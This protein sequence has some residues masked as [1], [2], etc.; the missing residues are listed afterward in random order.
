M[1]RQVKVIRDP[2]HGDMEFPS[3]LVT[4]MDTREF[5]RLRGVRQLGTASFVYPGAVHTRFDHSLGTCW[6]A[7]RLLAL[8]GLD[9]TGPERLAVLAYALLHDVTHVPFGHTLEDER[10][11][12]ERHDTPERVR[13]ALPRGELGA[14]L[15][16]LDLLEPVLEIALDPARWEHQITAG[17]VAADLLDYLARDAF[18]CGLSQRY[19]PRIFGL[20]GLEKGKEQW[21]L[22][23]DAQ[24]DGVLRQDALSEII[25]LL[26]IRYFLSERVY[27]HHTKTV[28]GAMISRAVEEAVGRDLT[29]ERLSRLTDEGLCTM[30]ESSYGDLP[31]VA[32]LMDCLRS[33]RLYKRVFLLTAEL[34]E[35]RRRHFVDLYHYDPHRRAQAEIDIARLCKLRPDQLIVYCPASKM[36]LKEGRLPVKVDGGPLRNLD[37]L[38]V[39]EI[40]ILKERHRLLWRFYV[41]LSPEKMAKAEAVAQACEVYF[42]ESNHLPR[43]RSGQLFLGV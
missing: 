2:V 3:D 6:T 8:L 42:G 22:Y 31:A 7:A 41:F 40:G 19:D 25:H 10:R 15:A 29:L 26:R 20:F 11:V 30:L 39:D 1:R 34:P 37:E 16:K 14:A 17:A 43:F 28:S 12:F 33:R 21:R 23:L 38:P 18:F 24:R 27:F 36:Q 4:L 32:H 5:Q 9:L 13:G 35:D